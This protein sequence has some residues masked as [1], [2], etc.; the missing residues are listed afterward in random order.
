MRS[1]IEDMKATM[2]TE[3]TNQTPTAPGMTNSL[4]IVDEMADRDRRRCNLVVY[5]FG[6]SDDR[7]K[8]IESFQGLCKDVFKL[9][10]IR[11]LKQLG[12]AQRYLINKDHY[13]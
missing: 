10:V 5:N 13:Y 8:D 7:K 3:S 6:E 11:L 9:D 1:Q 2:H 4:D 12:L